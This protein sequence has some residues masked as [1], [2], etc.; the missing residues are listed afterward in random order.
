M[1]T[2]FDNVAAQYRLVTE[3]LGVTHV[4]AVLGW[5]MAAAQAFQ[6]AV[7]YPDF[8]DAIVAYAGSAKTSVH[9]NVFLEGQKGY[10]AASRGG[11]SNGIG[12]GQTFGRSGPWGDK[13]RSRALKAFGRGYAGWGFSQTFY[14]QELFK[15][16]GFPDVEAFLG[17]FWET[18]A[19]TKGMRTAAAPRCPLQHVSDP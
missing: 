6:W 13:E 18:W 9:N 19:S 1:V 4:R 5:S 10:L 7:Q 14:R 16:L 8:M 12:K 11:W 17:D 3:A 2:Y 15:V